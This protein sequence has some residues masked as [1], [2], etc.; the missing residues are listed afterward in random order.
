MRFAYRKPPE[1]F[2]VRDL[3]NDGVSD[4]VLRLGDEG[5]R[6]FLSQTQ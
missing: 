6:V 4:L 5:L 3:N 1:G 2:D